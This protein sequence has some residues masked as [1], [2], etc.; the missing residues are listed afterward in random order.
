MD[1]PPRRDIGRTDERE[2]DDRRKEPEGDAMLDR[3]RAAESVI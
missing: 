3:A 2:S 1:T